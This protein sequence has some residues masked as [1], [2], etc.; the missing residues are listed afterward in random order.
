MTTGSTRRC[1]PT[2]SGTSSRATSP[3]APC[4]PLAPNV[5]CPSLCPDGTRIAFKRAIDNNP[6]R[7][8]RLSV[9]S[10]SDLSETALAETR[11]VDDQAAWLSSDTVGYTLR[12]SDGTPSVWA[13]PANGS[14]SPELVREDAESPASLGRPKR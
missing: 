5:E 1:R 4:G 3:D 13:V 8:W 2:A 12:G 7:G 11:S 9:L 14:G 6:C 10:L